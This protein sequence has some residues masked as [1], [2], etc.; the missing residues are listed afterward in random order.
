MTILISAPGHTP[1]T[2][3]LGRL[4]RAWPADCAQPPSL[5][6]A[7]SREEIRSHISPGRLGELATQPSFCRFAAYMG[8]QA[9]PR[10]PLRDSFRSFVFNSTPSVHSGAAFGESNSSP[11]GF[12]SLH[13][14]RFVCCQPFFEFV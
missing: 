4:H 1:S 11:E 7:C 2:V 6:A 8:L 3:R 9:E 10:D 14:V 13:L 5:Q 12:A